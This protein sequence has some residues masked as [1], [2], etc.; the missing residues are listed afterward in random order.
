MNIFRY[1]SPDFLDQLSSLNRRA[2]PSPEVG[3]TVKQILAAVAER[4]LE[5]IVKD[6]VGILF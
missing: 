3:E 6:D 4:A 1:D 5:N 2:S